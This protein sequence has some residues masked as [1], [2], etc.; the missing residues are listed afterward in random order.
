MPQSPTHNELSNHIRPRDGWHSFDSTPWM[1]PWLT[2]SNLSAMR[3]L[4]RAWREE[5]RAVMER[6]GG[7]RHRFAFVGNMANQMY[8]RARSLAHTGMDIEVF[9]LFGDDSVLSDPRWEEYD[10]V[11][12]AQ[13]SYLG[14]DKSFLSGVVPRLPCAQF[15]IAKTTP[16]IYADA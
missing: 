16:E 11:L 12:P 15:G 9:G 6:S 7:M 5:A 1:H 13:A 3:D 10:G 14:G 2:Y 4:S 8:I